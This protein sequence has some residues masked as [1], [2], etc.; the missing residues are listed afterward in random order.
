MQSSASTFPSPAFP[1]SQIHSGPELCPVPSPATVRPPLPSPAPSSTKPSPKSPASLLPGAHPFP[2][3]W[4]LCDISQGTCNFSE[5]LRIRE[6][7][8]RNTVCAVKRL[9][10]SDLEWTA[11]KQ[12]FL[13]EVKQLWSFGY[14]NIV[15][16]AGFCAESSFYGL[17]YKFLP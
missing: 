5:E 9:K 12:S 1:G 14:P 4:P 7:V 6:A 2:F 11:G 13:T 3:F 15:D 10:E 8:I 16:F 17:V